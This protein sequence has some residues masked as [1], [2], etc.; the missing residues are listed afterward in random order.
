MRPELPAPRGPL[1]RAL[2]DHWERSSRSS[3]VAVSENLEHLDALTDEDLQLA[4]WCCYALGRGG[5][6]DVDDQLAWDPATIQFRTRLEDRF[7]AALRSEHG[8]DNVPDE[9]TVALRVIATWAGPPLAQTV[10]EEGDRGHLEE[11]AIHRSAYQLKVADPHLW[12]RLRRAGPDPA[13][14]VEDPVDEYGVGRPHGARAELFAAAMVELGLDPSLGHYV[15][16]L[17]AT[18]LATENLVT[19]FGRHRRLR[20]ALVGH[21]ALFEM[22]SVATIPHLLAAARRVG[23]L[24]ALE[25]FCAVH[26][27]ADPH[28]ARAA[29]DEMVAPLVAAEPALGADVVFGAAALSRVEVRFA[30]HVLSAWRRDESSLLPEPAGRSEPEAD[31]VIDVSD[32]ALRR[33]RGVGPGGGAERPSEA[34]RTAPVRR[35]A[36][37][38]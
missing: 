20:G 13:A 5:L 25:R 7:E 2:F 21:L 19:M 9:P 16:R 3:E 27:E 1:T 15:A 32:A 36:T 23:G 24:P 28:P 38:A 14:V 12:G 37:N 30:R 35:Y 29:L 18:T 26:V 10:A 31:Q 22:S 11:F 8:C 6:E 4:L 34:D 33:E 17:P